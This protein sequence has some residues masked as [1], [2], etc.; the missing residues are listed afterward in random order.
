MNGLWTD[1]RSVPLEVLRD[2]ARSQ[3]EITSIRLVAEDAGVGRSTLH[4]FITAGTMPHPRVRRLLALWYLQ[5]LEGVDELELVRPYLAALAI[6]LLD[7]P[8]SS[9]KDVRLAVLDRIEQGFTDVGEEAPRWVTV[10]RGRLSRV[11]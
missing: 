1:H 11:G 5:R 2:F 3:S 7:V 9:L 6:L 10:L 4:K 8:D